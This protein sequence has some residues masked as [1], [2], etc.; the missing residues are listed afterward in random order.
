MIFDFWL[1][2]DSLPKILTGV[3]LT[4]QLLLVSLVAGTV[5]AVPTVLARMS[6]IGLLVAPACAYVFVF[7]GTPLLVQ[8][9]VIYYGLPQLDWVRESVLWLFL[10]DPY[11]C[12]ILALTLNH[13]AYTA[14]IFRGGIQGV[15]R[16]LHEAGWA[17][18]LSRRQ[19]FMHVT[20]PL[21][22]RLS[23]PPFGSETIG[24]L[25]GTALASTVTLMEI[26]GVA[27]TIVAQTFAP[28][29]IFLAAALVYLAMTLVIERG[30]A[31]AERRLGRHARRSNE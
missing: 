27:R 13:G 26:T 22:L 14:E 15:D 10:R 7:R 21:A 25:K 3:G 1:V 28:Y 5:L 30:V 12:A 19:R 9:F 11:W 8:I 6:G 20:A 17:L 31:L 4:L 18:G 16:G 24:L 29:E 2:F 23:L